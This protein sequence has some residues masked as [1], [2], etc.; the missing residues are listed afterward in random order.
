MNAPSLEARYAAVLLD[1][2]VCLP[3]IHRQPAATDSFVPCGFGHLA[4]L[5]RCYNGFSAWM[6]PDELMMSDMPW[7]VAWYGD[8][9]C[10]WLTVNSGYEF[11]QLCY[12]TKRVNAL[13]ISTPL[14]LDSA[15]MKANV[16][17]G[18]AR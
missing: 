15:L 2:V 13:Y 3:A 1:G 5:R 8:R 9:Q 17:L 7:A 6:R 14:T 10:A 12:Y 4:I 16:Y 18:A 11:T